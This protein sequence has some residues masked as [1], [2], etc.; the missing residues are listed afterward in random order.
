M[1]K[2]YNTKQKKLIEQAVSTY[3]ESHFT[4]ED[5]VNTIREQ[6]NTAGM[7]TV[8]R[9][10]DKMVK[11]GALMKYSSSAGESACYQLK[12]ECGAHFHLKCLSCGRLIHLSCKSLDV[13]GQHVK[14]EHD[15]VIDP[16]KTVFYGL[17]GDCK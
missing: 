1:E 8:Y 9:H 10:L 11:E 7:T 4:C 17:C 13:I 12:G 6:G 2:S 3:S 5:I 15:F 14:S 16:S